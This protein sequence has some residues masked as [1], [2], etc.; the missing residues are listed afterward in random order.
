MEIAQEAMN[1]CIS[2]GILP[3]KSDRFGMEIMHTEF[4]NYF[5][6]SLLKSDR[7]GME[8]DNMPKIMI[9]KKG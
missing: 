9:N 4:C 7:F 5:S 8:I 1:Y 6:F 2:I 3:L